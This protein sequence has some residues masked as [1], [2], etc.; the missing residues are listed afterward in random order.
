VPLTLDP[1]VPKGHVAATAG[2][3]LPRGGGHRAIV[4][5]AE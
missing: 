5:A 2:R 3:L 4:E 1:A